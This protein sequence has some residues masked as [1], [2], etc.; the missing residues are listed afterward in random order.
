M[1]LGVAGELHIGGA[2]LARGYLDR[3]DLTA[4]RF[5]PDPYGFN[6]GARV[7]KTGDL[8]RF[9]AEGNIEFLGRLDN[10]VKVRGFRLELGEIEAVLGEHPKVK[11]AIVM[12]QQ[13][14]KQLVAYVLL[15]Q[16]AALEVNEP[17]S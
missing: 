8:V 13:R 2:G 12:L 15:K 14:D 7:Y 11:E 1:P 16:P 17:A 9:L 4:E 5:L 6:K 10:Q 3:P